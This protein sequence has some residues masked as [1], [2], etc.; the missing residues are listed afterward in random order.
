MLPGTPETEGEIDE[1]ERKERERDARTVQL[2]L[3]QTLL[4]ISPTRGEIGMTE[5]YQISDH[6]LIRNF[7]NPF[8]PEAPK[9]T[10]EQ[11]P[12]THGRSVTDKPG[13]TDL[14]LLAVTVFTLSGSQMTTSASEPTA[15]RPFL[16]YRLKILAALVLVTATNWFSSILPVA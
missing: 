11:D 16:G 4:P 15:I 1:G 7:M 13:L 6:T 3:L 8:Q 14:W 2:S 9:M 10:A 5:S 12:F